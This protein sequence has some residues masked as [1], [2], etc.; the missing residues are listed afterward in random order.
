MPR[1]DQRIPCA[2]LVGA[3][4]AVANRGQ[5]GRSRR[6]SHA[7]TVAGTTPATAHR[8]PAHGSREIGIGIAVAVYNAR[9][10]HDV[11]DDAADERA[12]AEKYRAWSRKLAFGHPYVA[13]VLEGIAPTL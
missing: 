3:G 12:L 5:A 13:T 11:K 9:G 8:R 7:P 1:A 6:T 2:A 10:M 4:F